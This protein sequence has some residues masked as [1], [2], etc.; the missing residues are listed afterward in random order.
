MV[1]AVVVW[2]RWRWEGRVVIDVLGGLNVDDRMWSSGESVSFSSR[3]V[4]EMR[5]IE[6]S[7]RRLVTWSRGFAS[8]W[9]VVVALIVS[10]TDRSSSRRDLRVSQR[11]RWKVELV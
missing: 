10:R 8:D 11:T 3:R 6:V 5:F 9:A 7:V 1:N 2:E 4:V